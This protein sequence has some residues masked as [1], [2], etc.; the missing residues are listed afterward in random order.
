MGGDLLPLTLAPFTWK[1]IVGDERKRE[2]VRSI[3]VFV[4]KHLAIMCSDSWSDEGALANGCLQFAYPDV[5]GEEVELIDGGRDVPVTADNAQEFA[6]LYCR[7]DFNSID[8][9][10]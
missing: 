4:E 5:T 6:R 3:D 8:F 1:G 7:I 2:D 10:Y 9:N